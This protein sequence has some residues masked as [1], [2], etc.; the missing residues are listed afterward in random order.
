MMPTWNREIK[1]PAVRGRQGRSG[2]SR[3][4]ARTR[5]EL[6]RAR[7]QQ[8][9]RHKQLVGLK[10]GSSGIA[11]ATVMNDGAPELVQLARAPLAPGVVVA[12]EV[13]DPEALGAALDTLFGE[14]A[15]PRQSVRVGISSNRIGVRVLDL[16]GIDD[17]RQLDNAVRFRAQETLPIP[18]DETVLDYR[19]IGESVDDE[20][21]RTRRILLVVAYRDL[22]ER[23]FTACAGA[24]IKLAG[25]D[26]EAFALLRALAPPRPADS[27]HETALVG[28]SIGRE[29][30]T[31]AVSDGRVCEFARVLEW[32][33]SALDEAVAD[34]LA[35]PRDEAEERKRALSLHPLDEAPAGIS[36]AEATLAREA[37]RRRLGALAREVG[38]SLRFYESQE[39]A[40]RVDEVAITGGTAQL[41]G[42]PH[43]LERML[44]VRVRVADPLARVTLRAGVEP[45]PDLASSTVAIGLGIED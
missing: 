28:V 30:S 14:H 3:R 43:E 8:S 41:R 15:L 25:I 10:V 16:A 1:L 24:G 22:I 39:G 40:L 5:I 36:D 18:I 17:E 38:S 23:Y 9:R 45:T 33:G 32:G 44:G 6:P 34:A 37:M 29:R 42:L 2:P 31:F 7:A 20:G 26:L 27:G 13:N 35:L 4:P 11:A 19:V 21:V 12:G